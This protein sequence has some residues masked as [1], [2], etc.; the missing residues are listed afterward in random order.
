MIEARGGIAK[1]WFSWV[2]NSRGKQSGNLH[3][4]TKSQREGAECEEGAERGLS[5]IFSWVFPIGAADLYQRN[6]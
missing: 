6:T 3:E 5:H 4:S 2:E 1:Y